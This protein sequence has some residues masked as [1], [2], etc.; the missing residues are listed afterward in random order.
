[1]KKRI[2]VCL[3]ISVLLLTISC[4]SNENN[5]EE[6]AQ[7]PVQMPS[8]SI[9]TP[10]TEATLPDSIIN[11][12][13]LCAALAPM[14]TVINGDTVKQAGA[15]KFLKWPE[16]KRELKVKFLD[17]DPYVQQK[18]QTIAKQWEA[19]CGKTLNFGNWRKADITITF[20]QNGSWSYI[21]KSSASY[22][23]SMNFGWFS[24]NTSDEEF[25]R[26]TLHE[27]G[28]ALGLIHEH[29]NPNNN[30]IRWNKPVVYAYFMRPPNNWS[31]EQV[32][33]NLFEAYDQDQIN[34][35]RFDPNSI[36]LYGFP[37][38]LTQ[39][40]HSTRSNSELSELDKQLI[41]KI[42]PK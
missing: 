18:V 25:H 33:F 1:M 35:T 9:A 32:D 41:Q 17:G 3:S 5:T 10:S 34:G 12:L 15:L 14:D 19:Y 38:E 23:P 7:T 29:Q 20:R 31:K 11:K 40:G 42:Y 26:T 4:N 21:G 16:E 28:H 6:Q 37:R 13:Q 39:D 30:P 2:L 36:M 8:S 22:T 24:R 27:F